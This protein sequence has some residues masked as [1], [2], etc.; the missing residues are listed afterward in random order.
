MLGDD[1]GRT[2]GGRSKVEGR[3][4]ARESAPRVYPAQ[5][6]PALIN[7]LKGRGAPRAFPQPST[8]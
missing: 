4:V 5:L 3:S 6:P 2:E 7:A 1:E 8:L